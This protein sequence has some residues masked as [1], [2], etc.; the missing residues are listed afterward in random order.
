MEKSTQIIREL[1][2]YL[3]EI[4]KDVSPIVAVYLFGSYAKGKEK[5]HSDMDLAFLFDEK[6]YKADPF[7]VT[8]QAYVTALQIGTKFGKETDAVILNSSS[9]ELAYEAVTSRCCIYDADSDSR[10]EYEAR[11]RGMYYD[12]MPFLVKL[13]SNFIS[14]L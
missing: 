2:I 6:A 8:G 5:A 11:V 12:F 13:R 1:E 10:F 3:K 14:R 7:E 9:I 4:I